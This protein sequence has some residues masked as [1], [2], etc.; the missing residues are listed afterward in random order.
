MNANDRRQTG[1]MA[2][3]EV[4]G[5]VT[6]DLRM[7]IVNAKIAMQTGDVESGTQ[8]LNNA[9]RLT[10]IVNGLETKLPVVL[11]ASPRHA[12]KLRRRK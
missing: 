9:L 2:L 8:H 10:E 12:R 6:C 11:P 1:N 7:S 3:P 4:E 5:P